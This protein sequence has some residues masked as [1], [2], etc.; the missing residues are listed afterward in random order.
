MKE[1]DIEHFLSHYWQQKPVVLRGFFQDFEDP[2]DEHDLAGL[3]QEEEIDSRL[4]SFENTSG[5]PADGTGEWKVHQG[6][7]HDFEAVCEG[8]WTLLVQSVDRYV[9][10]VADILEPFRFLPNWR[11]DDLMVSF[12]TKNAGVGA[13]IDQYDVFLVQGKGQRRWRVGKPGEYKEVFPHPKL[14]QIEGFDPIIDEVLNPGDV[15]YIP[16]GWPHDGKALEDCLTYSVGFRAPETAQL[17]DSLSLMLETSDINLRFTDAGRTLSTTSAVV[18]SSDI[19][20][21]KQQLITAINS[22][23]FT[24]AL[25][26]SL[27][28]QGLPEYPP[29]YLY[30]DS[31]IAAGFEEGVEFAPAPGVRA[32]IATNVV[33]AEITSPSSDCRYFYVNG[34]RFSY[35]KEDEQWVQLLVNNDVLFADILPDLPSFAFLATLTTLINKGY[36]EW[37]EA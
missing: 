6:P 36:W 10:D 17:A 26:E 37:I 28:E 8:A 16:P 12:A 22:D 32:L 9:H 30:T 25:L 14:R 2:I 7:I 1:F 23:D 18:E 35:N 13:H 33:N 5:N 29:E 3:A 15:L 34:E 27:S 4:L 11:L 24:H 20:A 21:L 19:A 31:Q